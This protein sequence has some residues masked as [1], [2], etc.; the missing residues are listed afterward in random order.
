MYYIYYFSISFKFVS[1]KTLIL[2]YTRY[3][4]TL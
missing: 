1:D 4:N 3:L 2:L